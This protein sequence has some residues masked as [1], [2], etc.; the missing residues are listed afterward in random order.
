MVRKNKKSS[1]NPYIYIL[2]CDSHHVTDDFISDDFALIIADDMKANA[3]IAGSE[4]R[5]DE[6]AKLGSHRR[7]RGD[8]G[9]DTPNVVKFLVV[10][11]DC[12]SRLSV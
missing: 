4:K 12:Q 9:E 7:V 8:F 11:D 3:G 1:F 2:A 6:D 5:L 10:F